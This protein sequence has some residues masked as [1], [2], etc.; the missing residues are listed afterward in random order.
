MPLRRLLIGANACTRYPVT[1]ATQCTIFTGKFCGISGNIFQL[2]KSP[3][4]NLSFNTSCSFD[5]PPGVIPAI[6]QIEMQS[7]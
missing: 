1:P 6:Q 2:F 5:F 7:V 4:L 3:V